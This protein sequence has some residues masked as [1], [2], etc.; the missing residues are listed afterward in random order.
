MQ[1]RSDAS[2][3]NLPS[4]TNGIDLSYRDRQTA[5][6]EGQERQLRRGK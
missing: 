4:E 3:N 5:L 1:M 2:L 6:L